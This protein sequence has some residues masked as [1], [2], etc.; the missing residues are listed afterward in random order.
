MTGASVPKDLSRHQFI[1]VPL[2][3]A[4]LADAM[5][6]RRQRRLGGY[7]QAGLRL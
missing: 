7:R 1:D 4:S 5:R 2:G 3:A 6:L